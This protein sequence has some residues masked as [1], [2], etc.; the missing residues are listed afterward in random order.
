MLG[1]PPTRVSWTPLMKALTSKCDVSNAF[2]SF[3]LSILGTS[4]SGIVVVDI[5]D[6]CGEF[7]RGDASFQAQVFD[8]V[9]ARGDVRLAKTL[10]NQLCGISLGQHLSL[11]SRKQQL[12]DEALTTSYDILTSLDSSHNEYDYPTLIMNSAAQNQFVVAS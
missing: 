7:E 12:P 6:H 10:C 11:T 8:L 4:T 5:A 9:V 3:S 2:F 1:L